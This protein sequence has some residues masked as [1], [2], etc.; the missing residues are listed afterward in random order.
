MARRH[1][2]LSAV[3]KANR[4]AQRQRR[5]AATAARAV[6]ERA[7][8][9]RQTAVLNKQLQCEAERE[10]VR[11]Q[12][13]EFE[14]LNSDLD[15]QVEELNALLA[16]GLGA[17]GPVDFGALK[18]EPENPPFQPGHLAVHEPAPSLDRYTPPPMTGLRRFLPSAKRAYAEA[19]ALQRRLYQ[20]ALAQH[21]GREASREKALA[22]ARSAH[23]KALE[24]FSEEALE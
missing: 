14:D 1:G 3:L 8:Q 15:Q 19:I 4:V 22:Y 17:A 21:A 20:E 24:K 5:D 16:A 9:V 7:R 23:L 13:Q 6:R 10:H 11:Q 18:R 2:F 12:E